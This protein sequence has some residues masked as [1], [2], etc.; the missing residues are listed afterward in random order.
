MKTVV[1]GGAGFVG[2]HLVKRLVDD[3]HEVVVIDDLSSG[4][5]SNLDG[6]DAE[7][8]EASILDD[9]ALDTIHDADA[10]VHLAA[11]PSVP[12]SGASVPSRKSLA[13]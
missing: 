13:S 2:A 11:V 4:F 8:I 1:T 9:G 7:L 12:R 3:G 10:V 6:I 5:R